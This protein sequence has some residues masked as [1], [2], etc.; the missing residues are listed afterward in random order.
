MIKRVNKLE[1]L[2]KRV[3]ACQNTDIENIDIENITD[4]K[5]IKIDRNKTSMERILALLRSTSNPYVIKVN[6]TIVKMEF[7]NNSKLNAST[8]INNAMKNLYLNNC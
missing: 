3:M 1:E 2:E 7:T 5:N 6:E 4:I 8:C